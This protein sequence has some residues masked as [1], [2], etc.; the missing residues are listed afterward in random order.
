MPKL[1]TKMQVEDRGPGFQQLIADLAGAELTVGVHGEEGARQHPDAP[2][3]TVAEVMA[4]H[5]LGIGGQKERSWL[6]KFLDTNEQRYVDMA[7]RAMQD[8][9]R[10]ASRKKAT[11]H[12]GYVITD[13][14][15]GNIVDGKIQPALAPSTVEKKGHATPLL[16][17][18]AGVN[19]ITF[20]LKLRQIKSV[21]REGGAREA[22]RKK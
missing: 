8:I 4:M 18:A 5:E 7:K 17:S 3:M 15:R 2:E 9:L 16:A 14:M 19:A 21:S 6:R 22:L 13:E 11:E 12:I 1:R 10:G 20:R